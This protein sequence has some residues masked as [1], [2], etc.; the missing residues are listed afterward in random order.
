M[1]YFTILFCFSLLCSVPVQGQDASWRP[2][3]PRPEI[4]PRSMQ[5]AKI[6]YNGKPTLS[7]SGNGNPAA[8]G[9]WTRTITVEPETHYRFRTHFKA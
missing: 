2:V 7:L 4:A 5:D 1:K 6:T 9:C 3:S 8:D